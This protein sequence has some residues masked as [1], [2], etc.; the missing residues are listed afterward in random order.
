VGNTG[1]QFVEFMAYSEYFVQPNFQSY[2]LGP[3]TYQVSPNLEAL[4][5]MTTNEV[6]I[7]QGT[8]S[9]CYTAESSGNTVKI[10]IA[11]KA[12]FRVKGVV[13]LP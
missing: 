10:T 6:D 4:N 1:I 7:G 13:F 3:Q 12:V 5:T 11:F 9:D 8:S 2:W